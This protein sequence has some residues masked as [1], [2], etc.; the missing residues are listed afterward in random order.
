MLLDLF[1]VFVFASACAAFTDARLGL[2]LAIVAGVLQDPVRKLIPGTPAILAV[3]ALPVVA[4]ALVGQFARDR[5]TAAR[6]A[7]AHPRLAASLKLFALSLLPGVAILLVSYGAA[8]W[9]GALLGAFGYLTPLLA[10][11]WG[12][13]F[14]RD[15]GDLRRLLVFYCAVTTLMMAGSLFDLL[16]L[17]EGWPALGTA[18]LGAPWLRFTPSGLV[19]RLIS[20]FY[21]SPDV[22]GWHAATLFMGAATL[23]LARRPG[24][25]LWLLAAA[26]AA[27]AV[28]ICGRRKAM[29]MP[30]LWA[31]VVLVHFLRARRRGGAGTLLAL[32]AAVLGTLV[33]AGG[34]GP[35]SAEY[36]SYAA[37]IASDA[38]R[39]LQEG[40][41]GAVWWTLVQSGVLGAGI[42]SA[43]QGMQHLGGA[44]AQGWQ[45]SG[46]SKLAAELGLPG[47][48]C[49][50]FVALQLA[51]GGLRS[52]RL[53]APE[54]PAHH[55]VVGLIGMSV[56]NAASFLVSHQVYG[57]LLVMTLAAFFMGVA[58]SAPRWCAAPAPGAGPASSR[59]RVMRSPA[60]AE[61]S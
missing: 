51:R 14:V 8:A 10:I 43:S 15:D 7:R 38:P 46:A 48:L 28:L 45:E 31:A 4:A 17:F 5:R 61:V 2:R 41:F 30:A 6:F 26:W 11:V 52:L 20:G 25:R 42:G 3:S 1:G 13:S 23:A 29:I 27:F 44:V 37:S 56:A 49:G 24:A 47:L 54:S 53:S 21:R 34:E 50:L 36:Y 32:A 58:L 60:P 18:A 40:T 55:M 9:R 19:I 22:M 12:F 59:A 57:D 16:R 39:R 33:Y 35:I